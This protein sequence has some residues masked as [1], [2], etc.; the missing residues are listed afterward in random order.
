MALPASSTSCIVIPVSI[1][2][3]VAIS[4]PKVGKHIIPPP[5]ADDKSAWSDRRPV[6]LVSIPIDAQNWSLVFSFFLL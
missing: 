3:Q 1:P 6:V 4:N 5:A 2:T